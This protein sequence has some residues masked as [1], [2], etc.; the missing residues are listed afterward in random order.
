[1]AYEWIITINN[2]IQRAGGGLAMQVICRRT[3]HY[4]RDFLDTARSLHHSKT[5]RTRNHHIIHTPTLR[6]L[7][8]RYKKYI[9]VL[10]MLQI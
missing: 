7:Y 10:Q 5:I 6:P 8:T 1:M 2:K 4:C 3:A 9:F